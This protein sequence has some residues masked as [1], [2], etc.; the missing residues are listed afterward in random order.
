MTTL[1]FSVYIADEEAP[2]SLVDVVGRELIL[3]QLA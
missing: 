1:L 2:T 3:V